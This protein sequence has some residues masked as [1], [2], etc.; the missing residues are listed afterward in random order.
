MISKLI[1]DNN[2]RNEV[3][4]DVNVQKHQEDLCELNN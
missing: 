3:T 2:I 4:L 1:D